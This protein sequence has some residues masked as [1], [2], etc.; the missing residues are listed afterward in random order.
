MCFIIIF[1]QIYKHGS[2]SST[3]MGAP[4]YPMIANCI[5]ARWTMIVHV[6]EREFL[7]FTKI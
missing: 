4:F 2:K 6:S 7:F 3:Q 5:H 1:R